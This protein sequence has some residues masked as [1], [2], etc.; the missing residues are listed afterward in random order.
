M[1]H[2]PLEHLLLQVENL[3]VKLPTPNSLSIDQHSTNAIFGKVGLLA[4]A[5]VAFQLVKAKCAPILVYGLEC[6]PYEKQI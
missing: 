3:G 6:S 5:E 2:A 4:S 1:K